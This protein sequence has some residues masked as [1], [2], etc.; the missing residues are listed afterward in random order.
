M[1]EIRLKVGVFFFSLA[2]TLCKGEICMTKIHIFLFK[3]YQKIHVFCLLMLIAFQI[4]MNVRMNSFLWLAAFSSIFANLVYFATNPNKLKRR[5]YTLLA[6]SSCFSLTTIAIRFLWIAFM[7]DLRNIRAFFLGMLIFG[8]LVILATKFIPYR[9]KSKL[10]LEKLT[11]RLKI[12]GWGLMIFLFFYQITL[13][14]IFRPNFLTITSLTV[15]H[16]NLI[17]VIWVY[18]DIKRLYQIKSPHQKALKL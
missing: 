6:I 12:V 5:T 3:Q 10:T 11:S 8:C 4:V 7:I 13:S 15:S 9:K 1:N 2:Y 14:Y 17:L 18:F 16:F